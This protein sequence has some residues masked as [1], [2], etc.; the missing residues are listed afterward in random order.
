[1]LISSRN[2]ADHIFLGQNGSHWGGS[3]A[4]DEQDELPCWTRTFRA[5]FGG[6]GWGKR[7]PVHDAFTNS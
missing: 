4:G 2:M 1:M 6:T 7:A 5:G 3:L